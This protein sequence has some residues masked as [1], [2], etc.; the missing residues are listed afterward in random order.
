[1]TIIDNPN[2][3]NE[4]IIAVSTIVDFAM[5]AGWSDWEYMGLADR[6]VVLT[7]RSNVE[8]LATANRKLQSKLQ[9][10]HD[11]CGE[12]YCEPKTL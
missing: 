3:P 4:V 6:N 8:R 11:V 2:I 7:L 1:M 12:T 5:R 9:T 10:I